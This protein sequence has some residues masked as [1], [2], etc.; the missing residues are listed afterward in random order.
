[1]N[2]TKLITYLLI[3]TTLFFIVT[4]VNKVSAKKPDDLNIRIYW[5]CDGLNWNITN[6]CY[7]V[8]DK[9]QYGKEVY[10]FFEGIKLLPVVGDA[11]SLTEDILMGTYLEGNLSDALINL[12]INALERKIKALEILREKYKK[13]NSQ[14]QLRIVEEKL[15]D[16]NRDKKNIVTANIIRE[17]SVNIGDNTYVIEKVAGKYTINEM[18][19]KMMERAFD[20]TWIH[21]GLNLDYNS[22]FI[23]NYKKADLKFLRDV[24]GDFHNYLRA[25]DKENYQ[26]KYQ[27][28]LFYK[29]AIQEISYDQYNNRFEK[30]L[31]QYEK[32]KK[33]YYMAASTKDTADD[34]L[35]IN[36]AEELKERIYFYSP[37]VS[38]YID[39]LI[40]AS[41]KVL[42]K[43]ADIHEDLDKSTKKVNEPVPNLPKKEN[44]LSIGNK[45]KEVS[46]LQV[47]LNLSGYEVM[48]DG[49][50]GPSTKKAV[51]QFQKDHGL[52]MNGIVNSLTMKHVI[53]K[54]KK[55]PYELLNKAYKLNGKSATKKEAIFIFDQLLSTYYPEDIKKSAQKALQTIIG[56]AYDFSLSGKKAEA[57]LQFD[58]LALVK[59]AST[60]KADAKNA[61]YTIMQSAYD[62]NY[63]GNKEEAVK[64][65]DALAQVESVRGIKDEAKQAL[66]TIINGTYEINS[67][68]NKK[69][70]IQ[71]FDSLAQVE[72]VPGIRNEARK[73][74][75]TIINGTYEIN[76]R[77]EKEKAIQQFDALA[78]V[79]SVTGIKEEAKKALQ[80]ILT[81]A[82]DLNST[83]EKEKAIRYFDSL[84]QVKSV[85]SVREEAKK[86]LHVILNGA[87]DESSKGNKDAAIKIFKALSGITG[88]KF[89]N[90]TAIDALHFILN[91]NNLATKS[92]TELNAGNEPY[93]FDV[94]Y[95]N[96]KPN[97]TYTLSLKSKLLSGTTNQFTVRI[98]DLNQDV[99]SGISNDLVFSEKGESFT[100]T[101]P[102]D[103]HNYELL[104]YAGIAGNT[105][106]NKIEL[107]DIMLR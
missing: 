11:T 106:Q 16:L 62:L 37:T 9:M 15:K 95:W 52:V 80:T 98:Y 20:K 17:K 96:L 103:I 59:N 47:L 44:H 27:A 45:G 54:S 51:V 18:I 43:Q 57:T 60:I 31:V 6:I 94:L 35:F 48:I 4:P 7:S 2:R 97:T 76:A 41:Y 82:Y 74:L 85:S 105:Q 21:Y 32:I 5:D 100:F 14:R 104:I 29:L 69:L 81:G 77:G 92:S 102:N 55:Q 8:E 61:L 99:N 36:D 33:R 88:D 91:E 26:S 24:A 107:W 13:E 86:A 64:R 75:R 56:S 68:G 34:L 79:Q 87:Y 49:T 42:L 53:N 93:H 22:K 25:S 101:T 28:D 3:I 1:M 90:A 39:Q 67:K 63:K 65:F 73:A 12:G 66:R 10:Y 72:N 89:I 83:G 58:Y 19:I 23:L 78:Q 84:S 40:E 71:Q 30:L 70:A 38:G 50:F 46:E